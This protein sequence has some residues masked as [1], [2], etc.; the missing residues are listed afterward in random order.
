MGVPVVNAA[1]GDRA[2]R[3]CLGLGQGDALL[4]AVLCAS[5]SYIAVP[6]AMRLAIPEANPSLY[7]PMALALTFPFN[8]V[9]GLPL[10]LAVD[11]R[12]VELTMTP[13]KKIEIVADSLE[14]EAITRVLDQHGVSGYTVIRRRRGSRRP[15]R[16]PR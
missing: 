14:L 5:A 9:L 13:V 6:A 3:P 8:I 15:G 11:P 7:V 16:A 12:P 10:Y 1:V 2:S 4:F